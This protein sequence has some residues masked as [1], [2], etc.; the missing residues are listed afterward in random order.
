[1]RSRAQISSEFFIFVGFAFLIAIAFGLVSLDQLQDFR[2]EKENEAVKDLALKLQKEML[3]AASVEDGYVRVFEI[4]DK[5][6]NIDYFLTVQNNTVI[7]RSKN[8]F[9]AS[10]IPKVMGNLT[11]GTNKI[12][13]TGGVTYIN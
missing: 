1:M 4:P 13:K 11:K 12:N 5:L 9:Y 8:S 3:I 7:V 6:D 10:L 2:I